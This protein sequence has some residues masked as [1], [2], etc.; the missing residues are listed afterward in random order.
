[1]FLVNEFSVVPRTLSP[2]MAV[3]GWH[4]KIAETYAQIVKDYWYF[5]AVLCFNAPG[6]VLT[7]LCT[8]RCGNLR[9]YCPRDLKRVIGEFQ[10]RFVGYQQQ[11]SSELLSFLLDG[12]HEDLN[13]VKVRWQCIL[14][15]AGSSFLDSESS[16]DQ[17]C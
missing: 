9:V 6:F 12:L 1:M 8:N 2:S 11:D 10:Q 16:P 7:W 17:P 15:S 14:S 3:S 13:R 4:G 5:L